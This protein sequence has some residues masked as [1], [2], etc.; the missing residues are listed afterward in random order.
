MA[1]PLSVAASV[2]GITVPALHAIRLLLNDLQELRDAPS[3][4]QEP[5]K[6]RKR[7]A[8][9]A[10]I[11]ALDE[12]EL[13]QPEASNTPKM[14]KTLPK[15]AALLREQVADL[16]AKV[17]DLAVKIDQQ[18]KESADLAEKIN[19]QKR[20]SE[21]ARS[22]EDAVPKAQREAPPEKS[23]LETTLQNLFAQLDQ[24]MVLFDQRL[25]QITSLQNTLYSNT[26]VESTNA[27]DYR[28][29]ST[30]TLNEVRTLLASTYYSICPQSSLGHAA[31]DGSGSTGM[32]NEEFGLPLKNPPDD[33][34]E[35]ENEQN[36]DKVSYV[37]LLQL[38]HT[39]S[40]QH[41]AI[42]AKNTVR[43]LL[44]EWAKKHHIDSPWFRAASYRLKTGDT[45]RID[46]GDLAALVPLSTATRV[47][48]CEGEP[49]KNDEVTGW[50]SFE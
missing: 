40:R 19:Q 30:H 17:A 49:P 14:R 2:V 32:A 41:N 8:D 11:G 37:D 34:A 33:G 4:V 16:V 20:V 22:S 12:L 36:R 50:K 21:D 39:E 25:T 10:S 47:Y 44:F 6:S 26:C 27:L 48:Y 38:P 15:G 31:I 35:A 7:K 5:K 13:N 43:N 24:R 46:P 42:I 23:L 18:K 28:L 29:Q 9:A 1:D 3:T 45:L